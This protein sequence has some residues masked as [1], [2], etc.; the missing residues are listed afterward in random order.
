MDL[1]LD[2][3]LRDSRMTHKFL[4]GNQMCISGVKEGIWSWDTDLEVTSVQERVKPLGWENLPEREREQNEKRAKGWV[5]G[6]TFKMLAEEKCF[7]K[8]HPGGE[9]C[10]HRIVE[11]KERQSQIRG[12]ITW[13]S[14]G[15]ATRRLTRR[16]TAYRAFFFLCQFGYPFIFIWP[17]LLESWK[18]KLDYTS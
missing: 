8:V 4:S 5:L 17:I 7:P 2:N 12:R 9:K 14:F 13:C 11:L 6:K 15:W 1:V 10:S 18:Q 16:L 3:W